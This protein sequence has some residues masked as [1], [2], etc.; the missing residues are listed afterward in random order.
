MNAMDAS[1][2]P[3]NDPLIKIVVDLQVP[4]MVVVCDNIMDKEMC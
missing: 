3:K 2:N 1:I 4:N